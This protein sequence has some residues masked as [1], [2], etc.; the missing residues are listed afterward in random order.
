MI[1]RVFLDLPHYIALLDPLLD[2]SSRRAVAAS[3]AHGRAIAGR[4]YWASLLHQRHRQVKCPRVLSEGSC[5][6]FDCY[7][8]RAMLI[9]LVVDGI[10]D[11]AKCNVLSPY[12]FHHGGAFQRHGPEYS[13]YS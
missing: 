2:T 9:D 13:L 7:R 8:R 3:C 1:F 10:D 4:A 11:N 5:A 6:L 12:C